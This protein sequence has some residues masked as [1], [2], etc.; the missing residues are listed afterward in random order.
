MNSLNNGLIL[1][2]KPKD[3]TSRDVVNKISKIYGTK[4]VGHSGTLDP[5][6]TGVLV[7]TLNRYTKLN[8][9]LASKE[10]EYIAEVTLGIKTDTLDITGKILEE[11]E[12]KIDKESLLK[13]LK[14]FEK[15]YDQKVPLYSAVKID[16]KKL[17]EYARKGEKVDVPTKTVT[18]KKIE[19]LE[20]KE[21]KFTFKALVTK[22]T[23]IRSLINDILKELNVIG[24]MSNL[25][26][27]KQGIFKIEDCLNLEEI[28]KDTKLLKI[29]D[30]LDISSMQTNEKE[31]ILNGAK[32]TGNYP[33]KVLFLDGNEELAIYKKDGNVM[34][35]EV[36]LKIK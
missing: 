35:I 24:T 22:G 5:L 23:Y 32:L 7:I 13:V 12:E 31:K 30:V 16:G 15:T 3:I 19:L 20:F 18:I 9:I 6:A 21:N 10:K 8:E 25:Q 2:N 28:T 1:I 26:R 36:L 14:S 11:K 29:K 34:K 17:Y 27:T 4:K 33:N